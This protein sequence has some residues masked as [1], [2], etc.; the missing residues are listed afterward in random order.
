MN[1]TEE[2]KRWPE[3]ISIDFYVNEDHQWFL[4]EYDS[5]GNKDLTRVDDLTPCV[6]GQLVIKTINEC[7]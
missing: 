1:I 3:R 4:V 7:I 5:Y 2:S 6:F